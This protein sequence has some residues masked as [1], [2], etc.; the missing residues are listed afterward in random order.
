L[1]FD[2]SLPKLRA[3][4]RKTVE[5]YCED[6][7][8]RDAVVAALTRRGLA[9][10]GE[11]PC[12]TGIL[13]LEVYRSIRDELES[14]AWYAAAAVELYME[15]GFLFDHIADDELNPDVAGSPAEEMV[16]A[17]SVMNCGIAAAHE[18]VRLAPSASSG[19]RALRHLVL[20]CLTACAGQLQDARLAAREEVTTQDSQEMTEL[21]AGGCGRFSTAFA[22]AIATADDGLIERFGDFGYNLA[23]YSQLVDDLRDALPDGRTPNDLIQ[24]KKTVPLVYLRNS[25]SREEVESLGGIIAAEPSAR[26]EG[27]LGKQL[28]STGTKV[29]GEVVAE[30]YLN[31]AREALRHLADRLGPL[32]NIERLVEARQ[33][34]PEA[35]VAT[36]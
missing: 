33:F 6:R 24:G 25:M 9:L 14:A 7:A 16:I 2:E 13:A 26:I 34:S 17:I 27:E 20:N 32:D 4:V 1:E 23:V 31:A 10:N 29:F 28:D 8:H 35:V 15:A 19:S 21:K 11:A 12:R 22:A 3:T 36:Q 18:S 30:A 5:E